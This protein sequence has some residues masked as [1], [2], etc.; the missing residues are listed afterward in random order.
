[1]ATKTK[2]VTKT[3]KYMALAEQL[4]AA[5]DNVEGLNRTVSQLEAELE[6]C[7]GRGDG[8]RKW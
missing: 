5:L 3:K 2:D 1:M 7:E 6:D 8:D 4:E